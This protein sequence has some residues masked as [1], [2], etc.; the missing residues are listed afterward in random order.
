MNNRTCYSGGGAPPG[1]G[2]EGANRG[3]QRLSFKDKE[4]DFAN[5]IYYQHRNMG[6]HDY[7]ACCRAVFQVNNNED[8]RLPPYEGGAG[9]LDGG[10]INLPPQP[11]EN[12]RVGPQGQAQGVKHGATVPPQAPGLPGSPQA[13]VLAIPPQVPGLEAIV[14]PAAANQPPQQGGANARGG[15]VT[16]GTNPQD[17]SGINSA[18]DQLSH[19]MTDADMARTLRWQ[20]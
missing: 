7:E 3:R 11:N 4:Y 1:Q 9:G 8:N 15:G 12:F 19:V 14:P 20:R 17:Y 2:R 5:D 10:G 13:L 16:L 18:L 6:G